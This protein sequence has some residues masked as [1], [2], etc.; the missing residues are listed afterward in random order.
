LVALEYEGKIH[1]K[2]EEG[3]LEISKRDCE[4]VLDALFSMAKI[5]WNPSPFL[6][7]QLGQ[8]SGYSGST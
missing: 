8:A 5:V 7:N 2:I 4:R 1:Q 3:F 6:K